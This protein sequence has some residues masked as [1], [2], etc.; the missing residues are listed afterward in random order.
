MA[1]LDN[2]VWVSGDAPVLSDEQFIA[3]WAKHMVPKVG[4]VKLYDKDWAGEYILIENLPGPFPLVDYFVFIAFN[5]PGRQGEPLFLINHLPVKEG[6]PA[7]V[8]D[9][10]GGMYMM[11][12]TVKDYPDFIMR[13]INAEGVK[14]WLLEHEQEIAQE[15]QKEIPTDPLYNLWGVFFHYVGRQVKLAGAPS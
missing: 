5:V 13:R 2:K 14:A 3:L 15:M 8:R 6:C 7:E 1:I 9:K 10:M 4:H 12:N 11:M